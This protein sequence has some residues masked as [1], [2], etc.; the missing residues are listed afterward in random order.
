MNVNFLKNKMK[1]LNMSSAQLIEKSGV[2]ESTVKRIMRG[3][4]DVHTSTLRMIAAAI[5]VDPCALFDETAEVPDAFDPSNVPEISAQILEKMTTE[6]SN[7]PLTGNLT[8]LISIDQQIK[9][10]KT[11]E[12]SAN[13]SVS[14]VADVYKEQINFLKEEH[15][16]D[17]EH[18]EAAY[19][20]HIR[21]L[22][23]ISR[24]LGAAL[25]VVLALVMGLLI[26]D[27]F[28]SSVGWFR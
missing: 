11:E 22:R 25:A 15:E 2:S 13:I 27:M 26:Y 28:N 4:T 10:Q 9:T 24:L 6:E 17:I 3:K 21:T 8:P 1:E 19:R 16:K 23:I 5:G 20:A 12:P 14:A 7:D 18:M